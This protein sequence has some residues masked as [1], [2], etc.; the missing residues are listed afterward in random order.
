MDIAKEI[1]TKNVIEHAMHPRN[2]GEMKNPDGKGVGG[3]PCGD[4]MEFYIR[5]GKKK[6]RGKTVEYLKDVQYETMGCAAAIA[7]ASVTSEQAKGKTLEQAKKITCKKVMK[8]LGGMPRVKHHC[9]ELTNS[10]LQN[11]IK[12]WENKKK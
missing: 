8:I 10:A 7:T 2:R 5:V 11:A 6:L 9:C 1:Y 12:D 4:L 3:S